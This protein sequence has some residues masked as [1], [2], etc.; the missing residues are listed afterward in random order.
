LLVEE[1]ERVS[2]GHCVEAVVADVGPH[3][4]VVLLLDETIVILLEGTTATEG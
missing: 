4:R 1:I 2:L 3:E